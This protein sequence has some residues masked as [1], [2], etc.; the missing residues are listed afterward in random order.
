METEEAQIVEAQKFVRNRLEK[1]WL[2]Q[3]LATPDFAERQRPR[4]SVPHVVEDVMM[5]RK[6]KSRALLQVRA[7]VEAFG[8]FPFFG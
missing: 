4:S 7:S 1:K 6:R 5:Q 2:L 3:F 8:P